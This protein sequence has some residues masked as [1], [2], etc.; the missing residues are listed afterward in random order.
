MI[1]T[2]QREVCSLDKA[3][4]KGYCI[5]SAFAIFF[6]FALTNLS[7]ISD[8]VRW[9]ARLLS[10]FIVGAIFAFILDG[11]AIFFQRM[12]FTKGLKKVKENRARQVSAFLSLFLFIGFVV[13]IFT[14]IIPQLVESVQKLASDISGYLP[15]VQDFLNDFSTRADI[16]DVIRAK[17]DE[18]V[19]DASTVIIDAVSRAIPSVLNFAISTGT[20]VL[21][22][23]IAVTVAIY[24]L[25]GKKQLLHSFNRFRVAFFPPKL[26]YVFQELS[27]TALLVFRKY[28][29]G[30]LLD[31]AIIG[32]VSVVFLSLMNYPYAVLIGVLMGIS[33]IIPFFGSFIGATPSFLLILLIDP[34]KAFWYLVFVIVLQQ[35]NGSVLAPKIIGDSVGLPAIFVLL[36]VILGGSLFGFTGMIFGTPMLGTIYAVVARI[37]RIRENNPSWRF[38]DKKG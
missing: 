33:N 4:I 3:K 15:T 1:D 23:F 11:V 16:P 24:L 19:N 12:I 38:F 17:I 31:A 35:I 25:F 13:L 6:Y 32:V 7:N 29:N 5:V 9:I 22:A 27:E 34:V 28:I 18:I 10:P 36:S 30:Q 20:S 37:V 21:N 8:T 26:L 2:N 14:F